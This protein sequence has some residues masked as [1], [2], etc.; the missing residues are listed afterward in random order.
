MVNPDAPEPVYQQLVAILENKIRS[1]ELV[2]RLPGEREMA[3]I[4]GVS[5]G[6]VRHAMKLLREAGLI[7]TIHGR[8]TFAI[9]PG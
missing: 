4:Y 6:S 3:E 5:Y 7:R 8:G 9:P 1:G 2:G